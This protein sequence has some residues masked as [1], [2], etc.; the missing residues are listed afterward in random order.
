MRSARSLS[1]IP[2]RPIVN[3]NVC[4]AKLHRCSLRSSKSLRAAK[5]GGVGISD[6][7]NSEG[8]HQGEIYGVMKDLAGDWTGRS[9]DG[10]SPVGL[11]GER[12]CSAS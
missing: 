6:S 1:P 8:V 9:R 4:V 12:T 7:A 5:R 10:K 11:F 2:N 3:T